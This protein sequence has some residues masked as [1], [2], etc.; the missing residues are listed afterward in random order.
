MGRRHRQQ[1]KT[2]GAQAKKNKAIQ[3]FFISGNVTTLPLSLSPPAKNLLSLSL[4]PLS[5]RSLLSL[6]LSLSPTSDSVVV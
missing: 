4:S 2:E 3:I 6:S 1:K 5:S